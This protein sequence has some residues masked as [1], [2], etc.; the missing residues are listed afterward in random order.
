[1]SLFLV[2]SNRQYVD[3]ACEVWQ[4]L[5]FPVQ[6]YDVKEGVYVALSS[7]YKSEPVFFDRSD[8]GCFF[9]VGTYFTAKTFDPKKIL[10]EKNLSKADSCVFKEIFGHYVFFISSLDGFR[11]VS[12]PV[13]LI[14]V[15]YAGGSGD[16]CIGNDLLVVAGVMGKCD[17]SACGV[18]EF[19]LNENTIGTETIFVDV[20]RV[21]LGR[22]IFLHDGG[23][24]ERPFHDLTPEKMDFNSYVGRISSYFKALSNYSGV[25]AAEASAGFDTRLV[26]ACAK[27]SLS[28]I[29]LITNQNQSDHGVDEA[30]SKILARKLGLEL[31]VVRRPEKLL[32]KNDHLLHIS[33]VGRDIVRSAAWL[34]IASEKYKSAALVLG[35]YGG[36]A[37]R[38]KYC[39]YDS[40]VEFALRFYKADKLV[41]VSQRKMLVDEICRQMEAVGLLS[42][43]GAKDVCNRIYALDRMRVWGGA[44]TTAMMIHGDRLHPFMDWYLLGP[45]LSFSEGAVQEER[46]QERLIEWFSPGL[47]ELAVNPISKIV[48]NSHGQLRFRV[49]ARA[50]WLARRIENKLIVLGSKLRG[51]TGMGSIATAEVG[52]EAN[53]GFNFGFELR[54]EPV[55]LTR[56]ET[57]LSAKQR[58]EGISNGSFL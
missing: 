11:V 53:D 13:G 34:D 32:E 52:E 8:S 26:V 54:L 2:S 22:E 29:L 20:K 24:E 56:I 31:V 55:M 37:I 25:I 28:N 47:M 50:L 10:E 48:I 1:M 41:V 19:V 17:L 45:I 46:L 3:K 40:V 23:I 15:Y 44:A 6:V 35:G 27:S 58:A 7:G 14:N 49:L 5:G 39:K 36:E 9:S 38:A 43:G 51:F 42:G 16:F 30:L 12:D 4:A 57:L 21:G 33:S 18:K